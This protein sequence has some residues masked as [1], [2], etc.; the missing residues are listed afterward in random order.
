MKNVHEEIIS[1]YYGCGSPFPEALDGTTILDLGCGTGRDVYV[2][3][4][5]VGPKGKAIGLDMTP[6]QLEVANWHLDWHSEKF[7]YSNVKFKQGFIE[8][9]LEAGI[10]DNSIDIV[11][12]NCVLNLSP[13]KPEVFKEIFRVL[14]PG[15]ELYF[16]DV[17]SDKLI[18]QEFRDDKTLW[19]E[20]ISGALFYH[21]FE[22]LVHEI[23]FSQIRWISST[24]I[25]L[26]DNPELCSKIDNIK[27]ASITTWLFKIRN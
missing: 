9:L 22:E 19:G 23:G 1:K 17:Y 7:G 18:P 15:G 3:A 5:L 10:E 20:C 2:V 13:N 25:D 12:S 24:P 4:Q 6:E 8:N 14:K 27:F 21:E 11:I 16:S 26:S